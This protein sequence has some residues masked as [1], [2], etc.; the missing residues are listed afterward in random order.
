MRHL[1]SILLGVWLIVHGLRD[2]IHLTFRYDD[3]AMGALAIVAGALL[4]IR[5]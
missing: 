1:G 5:R 3:L 2:I 4:F